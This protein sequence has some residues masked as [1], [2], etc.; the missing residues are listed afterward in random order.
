MSGSSPEQYSAAG[1]LIRVSDRLPSAMKAT[2]VPGRF[3][4]S[5]ASAS[6]PE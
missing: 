5:S 1:S 2:L 6:T 3:T 4:S